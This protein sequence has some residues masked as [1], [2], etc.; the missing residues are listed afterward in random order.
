MIL[1]LTYINLCSFCFLDFFFSLVNVSWPVSMF[2]DPFFCCVQSAFMPRKLI[3]IQIMFFSY[4]CS[5]G[6]FKD[7]YISLLKF[8][9]FFIFFCFNLFF[10]NLDIL[11]KNNSVIADVPAKIYMHLLLLIILP[12]DYGSYFLTS[13]HIWVWS[14]GFDGSLKWI[15]AR[16]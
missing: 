3:L 14:S 10:L 7:N 5:C 4:R 11:A 6:S 15:R 13:S 8:S 16:L 1:S 12:L 9:V 2:I